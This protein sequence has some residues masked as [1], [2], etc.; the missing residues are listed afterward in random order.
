MIKSMSESYVGEYSQ[1]SEQNRPPPYVYVDEFKENRESVDK[2]LR[3]V[4]KSLK[5]KR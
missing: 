1:A 4:F 3:N 5:K 2:K